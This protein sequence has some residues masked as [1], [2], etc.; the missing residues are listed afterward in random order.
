MN[1]EVPKS[2]FQ[3]PEKLQAPSSKMARLSE[4]EFWRFSGIW[5][6]EFGTFLLG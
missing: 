1:R 6:L 2:K 3:V 5:N 4:L